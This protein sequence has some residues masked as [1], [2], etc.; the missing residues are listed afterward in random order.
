MFRSLGGTGA[1]IACWATGGESAEAVPFAPLGLRIGGPDPSSRDPR[2]IQEEGGMLT[3][4][5][6][7]LYRPSCPVQ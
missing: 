3:E 6:P 2:K 7:A 5:L 1:V 4:V